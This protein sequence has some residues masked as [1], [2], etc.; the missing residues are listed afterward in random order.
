MTRRR[1]PEPVI[2]RALYRRRLSHVFVAQGFSSGDAEQPFPD[3]AEVD[4]ARRTADCQDNAL[5]DFSLLV[6]PDPAASGLCLP[7]RLAGGG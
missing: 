7:A 4:R 2:P 6:D 5:G 3:I 1:L